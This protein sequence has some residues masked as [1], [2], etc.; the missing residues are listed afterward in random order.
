MAQLNANATLANANW[1]L[2]TLEIDFRCTRTQI[3]TDQKIDA[4]AEADSVTA[5]LKR[6]SCL[7]DGWRGA[8]G[9]RGAGGGEVASSTRHSSCQSCGS[10]LVL[11]FRLGIKC[12]SHRIN[13]I[14]SLDYAKISGQQQLKSIRRSIRQSSSWSAICVHHHQA[15]GCA[16]LDIYSGLHLF[17]I[18]ER[19]SE[20]GQVA[21][22]AVATTRYKNINKSS[23][24]IM[25]MLS[26]YT[27]IYIYIFTHI[28]IFLVVH[29]SNFTAPLT[30]ID[31]KIESSRS[32]NQCCCCCRCLCCCCCCCCYLSKHSTL[33]ARDFFCG[34]LQQLNSQIPLPTVSISIFN[35]PIPTCPAMKLWMMWYFCHWDVF[36]VAGAWHAPAI[37]Y[38]LYLYIAFG[39]GYM[40]TGIG[41]GMSMGMDMG[42]GL[43]GTG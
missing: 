25:I 14:I 28:Y 30:E 5:L 33:E 29:L 37:S 16:W 13:W 11:H 9:S 42:H 3:E 27:Y 18:V 39:Y 23:S 10:I 8:G 1:S 43:N 41:M 6:E 36:T 17:V 7:P 2:A 38:L 19:R 31:N 40:G 32:V 24:L 34:K 22:I 15:G 12:T 35:S 4:A 20:N 26:L 21:V